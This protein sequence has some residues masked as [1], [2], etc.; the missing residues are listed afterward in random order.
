MADLSAAEVYD[1]YL[2]D[3]TRAAV[4]SQP[5]A[6]DPALNAGAE[7]HTND[8]IAHNTF[9]HTSDLPG[10]I[11]ANGFEWRAGQY[12]IFENHAWWSQAGLTQQ[13]YVE[14]N[15]QNLVNSPTHYAAM[16]DPNAEIAG[17]GI[18]FGPAVDG[19]G[20]TYQGYSDYAYV[21]ELF[22]WNERDPFVTGFVFTD[23][24]GD[25]KLDIGEGQTGETVTATN[26]TTGQVLTTTTDDGYYGI[27]LDPNSSWSVKIGTEAAT[28]IQVGTLNVRLDDVDSIVVQPPTNQT[29]RGNNSANVLTGGAGNDDIYGLG[30]NDTITGGAGDDFLSGGAGADTFVFGVGFGHDVIQDFTAKGGNHDVI[31]IDDAIFGGTFQ[32]LMTHVRQP[33]PS[34]A[35]TIVGDDGSAMI[36]LPGVQLKDLSASDF[37]FF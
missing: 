15:H 33:S 25:G 35:L 20:P 22:G 11:S 37:V 18:E 32:Q 2:T 6:I 10:L 34:S 13:Q 8:Q 17:V 12:G 16:T 28:T 3:A 30:G 9:N 14:T 27:E 1:L 24:D 36:E 19:S 29:L 7:Y 31:K 5:L 21:T 23:L 26:L 4:G